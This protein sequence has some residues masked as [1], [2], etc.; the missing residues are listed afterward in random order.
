MNGRLNAI[1]KKLE[2]KNFVDR[3]P[4]E[5]IEHER[6]KFKDYNQQLEKLEI[7]LQSLNK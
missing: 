5:I 4:K 6:K 7:N 3:A 2:N 1:S